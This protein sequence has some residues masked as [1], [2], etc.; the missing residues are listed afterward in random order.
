M[1]NG[2]SVPTSIHYDREPITFP[3]GRSNIIDNHFVTWTSPFLLATLSL[4]KY[5]IIKSPFRA[6]GADRAREEVLF[7]CMA[8]REE[9]RKEEGET[10]AVIR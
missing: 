4:E 6:D 9:K 10:V 2:Q 3:I 5:F 8:R 1:K 7:H